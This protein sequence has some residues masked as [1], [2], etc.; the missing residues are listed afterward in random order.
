[1]R[2]IGELNVV[3]TPWDSTRTPVEPAASESSSR[4]IHYTHPVNVPMAP[5]TAKACKQQRCNKFGNAGLCLETC[6]VVEDV[7]MTDCFVVDDRLWVHANDE[8]EGCVLFVT[9]QIRFV[10][11]TVYSIS[12]IFLLIAGY[13]FII[14]ILR[15]KRDT[16][17][18]DNREG[19]Q[20]RICNIL[21]SIRSYGARAGKRVRRYSK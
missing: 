5:P 17:P 3:T 11:G 18:S 19:N 8:S 12:S 14:V 16:F 10:K 1:M 13:L 9:F 21:E 15:Q 2:N 20:K 4:T 6:T 7:P